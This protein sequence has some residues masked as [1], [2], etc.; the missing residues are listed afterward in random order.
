MTNDKHTITTEHEHLQLTAPMEMVRNDDILNY[1]VKSKFIEMDRPSVNLTYRIDQAEIMRRHTI[2][3]KADHPHVLAD[4]T[5]IKPDTKLHTVD[6]DNDHIVKY[7]ESTKALEKMVNGSGGTSLKLNHLNLFS[8]MSKLI[9]ASA[10]PQLVGYE[11]T[12]SKKQE[13]VINLIKDEAK[14]GKKIMVFTKNSWHAE[15]IYKQLENQ[16]GIRPVFMKSQHSI[17][18]R[19]GSLNDF[20]YRNRNVLITPFSLCRR[21]YNI[22]QCA[23][24]IEADMIWD[25]ETRE[26]AFKRI[27]RPQQKKKPIIH[28]VISRRMIDEYMYNSVLKKSNKMSVILDGASDGSNVIVNEKSIITMAREILQLAR[29]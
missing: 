25:V 24:I 12:L 13:K 14:Y 4:M 9:E 2:R 20:R 28:S 21:G 3:V 18:K 10:T 19:I 11:D 7:L 15:Y 29:S 5:I 6:P 23:V 1:L 27:L 16:A 8:I 22:P 17:P 26:Q